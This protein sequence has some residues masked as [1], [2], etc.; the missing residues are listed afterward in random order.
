[1]TIQQQAQWYGDSNLRNTGAQKSREPVTQI[2]QEINVEVEERLEME[3]I[4]LIPTAL[5]TLQ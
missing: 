2:M 4:V 3:A 5:R 1:V